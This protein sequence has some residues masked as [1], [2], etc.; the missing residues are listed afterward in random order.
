MPVPTIASSLSLLVAL[1]VVLAEPAGAQPRW[2]VD[3]TPITEIASLAPDGDVQLQRPVGATR[4][5]DGTIVVADA[6]LHTVG[7]FD[8]AGRKVRSRGREGAGPGEFRGLEWMGQCGRDSV[9]IWDRG[10][11]RMTVLDAAGAVVREGPTPASP[12]VTSR[13]VYTACSRTGTIGFVSMPMRMD[14]ALPVQRSD[15]AITIV[16]PGAEPRALGDG[17]ASGEFVVRGGGGIPRPLG[18]TT[19]IALAGDQVYVGTGDSAAVL[20]YGAQGA[21]PRRIDVP[22]AA[23]RPVRSGQ[24]DRAVDDVLLLVPPQA[25]TAVRTML[26]DVPRVERLPHYSALRTDRGGNLWIIQAAAGDPTR[27]I[28]VDT[29]GRTL[30]TLELPIPMQVWDVGPDY[31]LGQ[32]YNDDGEPFIV[33][34]RIRRAARATP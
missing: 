14:P 26:A 5:S 3:P 24:F 9:T 21:P 23:D 27:L 30:G 25:A 16:R 11:A 31:V 7:Y 28:A 12:T 4:L 1:L 29:A 15:A 2:A 19:T 22:S 20:V 34:Y 32:R 33:A 8:A 13:V 10:N 18:H 17:I 6:G